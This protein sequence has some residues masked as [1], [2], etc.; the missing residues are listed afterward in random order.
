MAQISMSDSTLRPHP[1][2]VIFEVLGV[3]L[4]SL[5]IL[6]TPLKA[7]S[8]E[9]INTKQYGNCVVSDMVDSVD[10]LPDK[11]GYSLTCMEKPFLK[12]MIW[13][14]FIFAPTGQVH[15]IL[16]A[17]TNIMNDEVDVAIYV[18]NHKVSKGEW[19]TNNSGSA[20]RV[21]ESLSLVDAVLGLL[22]MGN[23]AE[24]SVGDQRGVI[25]LN[26]SAAAI[27]DFKSRIAKYEQ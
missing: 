21:Y 14:S 20:I 16:S 17:G 11:V 8:V 24:I 7:S 23:I 13:V 1:W 27:S 4:T 19:P 12:D 22:A 5:M 25:P 18:D 10:L 6:P 3:I 15:I 9:E 2:R 26:D